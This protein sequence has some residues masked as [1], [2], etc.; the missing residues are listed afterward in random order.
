[1]MSPEE[2]KQHLDD[3]MLHLDKA[4]DAAKQCWVDSQAIALSETDAHQCSALNKTIKVAR[5]L[6]VNSVGQLSGLPV[7]SNRVCMN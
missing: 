2:R 1:M 4:T 5:E 7:P 3:R 6:D